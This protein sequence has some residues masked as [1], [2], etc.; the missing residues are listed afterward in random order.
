M[1]DQWKHFA[2]YQGFADKHTALRFESALHLHR[3]NHV[4]EWLAVAQSMI[5]QYAEFSGVSLVGEE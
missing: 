1:N 4:S 5:A 3:V 2:V